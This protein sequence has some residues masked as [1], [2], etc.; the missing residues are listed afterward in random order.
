[1]AKRKTKLKR[2]KGLADLYLAGIG[3]NGLNQISRSIG[4]GRTPRD[5]WHDIVYPAGPVAES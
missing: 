4:T 3:L 5:H 1:M 2:K